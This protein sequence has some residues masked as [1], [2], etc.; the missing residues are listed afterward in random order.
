MA[1]TSASHANPISCHEYETCKFTNAKNFR[2]HREHLQGQIPT[3]VLEPWQ[4]HF[5]IVYESKHHNRIRCDKEIDD[6]ES[7][8]SVADE[9]VRVSYLP[10]LRIK[11][12]Y[13]L[14]AVC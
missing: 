13:R 3:M 14:A 7:G 6:L 12:V 4:Y 5:V 9:S 2:W 1:Q 11:R 10:S 8:K